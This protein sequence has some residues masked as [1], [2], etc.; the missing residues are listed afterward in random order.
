MKRCVGESK[1]KIKKNKRRKK[2]V[3]MQPN[4]SED[5]YKERKRMSE[6]NIEKTLFTS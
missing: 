6:K 4:P 1:E 3:S 5:N 2:H